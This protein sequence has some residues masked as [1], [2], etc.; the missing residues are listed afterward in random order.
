MQHRIEF[1]ET[2]QIP[3]VAGYEVSELVGKIMTGTDLIPNHLRIDMIVK[4]EEIILSL[5]PVAVKLL[6]NAG[7]F[8]MTELAFT[9]L[10]A[11]MD[12][13]EI[14]PLFINSEILRTETARYST[15]SEHTFQ[16]IVE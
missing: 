15:A 11:Y 10:K 8:H 1:D 4:P 2:A 12:L 13:P 6:E 16:Q 9:E 7:S 5:A 14:R 3:E